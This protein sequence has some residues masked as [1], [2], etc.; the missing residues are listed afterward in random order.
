[1]ADDLAQKILDA[2]ERVFLNIY[3]RDWKLNIR[4]RSWSAGDRAD[5]DAEAAFLR[6]HLE[7]EE[8]SRLVVPRA[9][10]HSLVNAENQLL[11]PPPGVKALR[12]AAREK[13]LDKALANYWAL[14]R[15]GAK[16]LAKL[17]NHVCDMNALSEVDEE[18]IEKN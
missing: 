4:L 12:K 7:E 18:E 5:F 1:M 14:E 3:V 17:Y 10:A 6:D 11:F 9:I 8:Y 15:K 2:P 16:P 13:T